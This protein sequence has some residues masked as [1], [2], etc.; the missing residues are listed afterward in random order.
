MSQAMEGR[1]PPSINGFSLLL[2]HRALNK[3]SDSRDWD[4]TSIIASYILYLITDRI[5]E[6]KSHLQYDVIWSNNNCI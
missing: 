4:A 2:W 5:K 1:F 3:A 6:K